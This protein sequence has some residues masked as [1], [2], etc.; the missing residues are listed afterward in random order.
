LTVG[1]PG[2]AKDIVTVGAT[3]N[4]NGE[5][6]NM[7]QFSSHGPIPLSGPAGSNRL[8]PTIGAPGTLVSANYKDPCGTQELSGTSMATPTTQ[9]VTLLMRQ[10]LWDG[11]YPLGEA[12]V[13]RELRNPAPSAALLKALLINSGE[14]MTGLY[15]DNGTGGSW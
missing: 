4:G 15:T 1:N 3:E 9:G 14:R 8:A 5:P 10:Y 6:N 12:T 13:G 7:A 2:T 11:Y